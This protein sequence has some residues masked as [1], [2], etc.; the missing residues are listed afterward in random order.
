MNFH[1]V[2]PNPPETDFTISAR[3]KDCLSRQIGEALKINFSKDILLNSKSEYNNNSLNRI[4]IQ[5]D[6]WERRERGRQE[7]EEEK[8]VKRNVEDFRRKKMNVPADY[9]TDEEEFDDDRPDC[10]GGLGEQHYIWA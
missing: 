4:S 3:F 10:E 1:P 5:E 7:E 9:S 2:L 6:A 8:L